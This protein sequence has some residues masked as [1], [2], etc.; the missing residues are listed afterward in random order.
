MR[1]GP[2]KIPMRGISPVAEQISVCEPQALL[3]LGVGAYCS[4][5]GLGFPIGQ[6]SA[7]RKPDAGYGFHPHWN[8]CVTAR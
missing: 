4:G 6:H 3:K 7:N 8:G 1:L 5:M 2:H